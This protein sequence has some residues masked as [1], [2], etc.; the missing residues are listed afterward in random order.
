MQMTATYIIKFKLKFKNWKTHNQM[1]REINKMKPT[2][3]YYGKWRDVK[4]IQLT[5][6]NHLIIIFFFF[7]SFIFVYFYLLFLDQ[8]FNVDKL[9]NMS[10]LILFYLNE[11]K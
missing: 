5:T 2:H 3:D 8:L 6:N 7:F 9:L 1:S 10:I 4:Q 11:K